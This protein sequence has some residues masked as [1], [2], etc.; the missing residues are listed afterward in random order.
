VR[1]IRGKGLMLAVELNQSYDNLAATFLE[2]GLVVNITGGGTII[3]L[4]PAAIMDE[5]QTKQVAS[6]IHDGLGQLYR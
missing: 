3:R 6:I 2:H 4:L 1:D 5:T